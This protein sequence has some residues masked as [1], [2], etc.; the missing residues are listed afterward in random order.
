MVYKRRRKAGV[1]VTLIVITVILTA[2]GLFDKIARY[3][4]AGTLVPIIGFANCVVSPAMEFEVRVEF[5][6]A[7]CLKLQDL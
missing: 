7:I 6:Q 5:R 2:T 4:G 1:S 3:A